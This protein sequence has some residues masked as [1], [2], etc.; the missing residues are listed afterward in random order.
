M[1]PQVTRKGSN[2][3]LNIWP[4]IYNRLCECARQRCGNRKGRKNKNTTRNCEVSSFHCFLLH[5]Q[6][7][8]PPTIPLL[9]QQTDQGFPCT[10]LGQHQQAACLLASLLRAQ[11]SHWQNLS[12]KGISI[13]GLTALAHFNCSKLPVPQQ[14]F[15]STATRALWRNSSQN[16]AGN[17]NRDR[18]VQHAKYSD[19]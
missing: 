18:T 12:L 1:Q 13:T 11:L 16:I 3:R 4:W 19:M 15:N 6:P 9:P 14:K 8:F 5:H 10:A 7:W 2:Q 17:T